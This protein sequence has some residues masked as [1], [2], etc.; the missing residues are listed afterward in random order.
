MKK[1]ESN[2]NCHMS[3][4][5]LYQETIMGVGL[6]DKEAMVYET[7]LRLGPASIP[8]LLESTT[9][10]RGD[11][12]NI[13]HGLEGWGLVE[14]SKDGKKTYSPAHPQRLEELLAEQHKEVEQA[15]KTVEQAIPELI[16]MFRLISGKPGVRFF[17]GKEG[18]KEALYDTLNATE[19]VYTYVD[20]DA[21]KQYADD[22]NRAYVRARQKKG[23]SKRLLVLDTPGAREYLHWQGREQTDV[24]FLSKDMKPFHTGMQIYN[25]KISYFTLREKNIIAVLIE[26][27]DIYQMHRRMFE[28][29]WNLSGGNDGLAQISSPGRSSG[30][31]DK[32]TTTVKHSDGQVSVF[33]A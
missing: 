22:I 15:K 31:G 21:V 20:L 24:R 2:V 12:Y 26:D 13:L 30:L 6:T 9:Y 23:V 4:V 32:N 10:K 8:K 16:S 28:F 14:V 25:N 29:L 17:E 18:F 11:L 7:L 1:G 33:K 19:T 5:S 27:P 3:N